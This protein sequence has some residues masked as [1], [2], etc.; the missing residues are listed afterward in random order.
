MTDYIENTN[1][2]RS[3]TLE[4]ENFYSDFD[5]TFSSIDD[6]FDKIDLACGN[7][8]DSLINIF[9]LLQKHHHETSKYVSDN[10]SDVG[11]NS[12]F[13]SIDVPGKK[14]D[15]KT[16]D[17]FLTEVQN[18]LRDL[19]NYDVD[20][21]GK[22]LCVDYISNALDR[23]LDYTKNNK[24]AIGDLEYHLAHVLCELVADCSLS[25][26]G[27]IP[28]SKWNIGTENFS[29]LSAEDQLLSSLNKAILIDRMYLSLH[30]LRDTVH[31]VNR[32]A[33]T[34]KFLNWKIY[35]YIGFLNYK[36][37]NYK[38]AIHFFRKIE[39]DGRVEAIDKD[40]WFHSNLLI[41]YCFEY[42]FNFI[43]AINKLACSVDELRSF[44]NNIEYKNITNDFESVLNR[45]FSKISELENNSLI[46]IYFDHN[47][48][49]TDSC[50]TPEQLE[51]LHALAHCINEYSAIEAVVNNTNSNLKNNVDE[52]TESEAVIS[53]T[54]LNFGDNG[55]LVFFARELMRFIAKREPEYLTCYA[56]I[57]GECS[58]YFKAL[59][60]LQNARKTLDRR[61]TRKESLDAEIDFFEYYFNQMLGH[62]VK[63]NKER[64][65]N[66]CWKYSD[67]DAK[68]HIRIFEFKNALK[69][70]YAK[71]SNLLGEIDDEQLSQEHLSHI[72][73]PPIDELSEM[74]VE[75]CKLSQSL[76][77]N[78][79]V[80]AE[81]RAVQRAYVCIKLFV[82]YLSQNRNNIS[83]EYVRLMNA[84]E[85]FYHVR[86]DYDLENI[87][88]SSESEKQVTIEN[89]MF[90]GINDKM[91]VVYCLHNCESIFLLA[92]ISG[93]VVFQ[94]QTGKLNE[95]FDENIF[96][97]N[98]VTPCKL[99]LSSVKQRLTM[100]SV[101]YGT[102]SIQKISWASLRDDAVI[103]CWREPGDGKLVV[104]N[105]TKTEN[106]MVVD[107]DEF[108]K[109]FADL[110]NPKI[111]S[112]DNRFKGKKCR[113]YAK[114]IGWTE[115]INETSEQLPVFIYF[116]KRER[117]EKEVYI[118]PQ[119]Y[120]DSKHVFHKSVCRVE[121]IVDQQ[122]ES[123][124]IGSSTIDK[125]PLS[126]DKDLKQK[127]RRIEKLINRLEDLKDNISNE[128]DYAYDD[129]S[130][131][132]EWIDNILKW[133]KVDDA[134][135]IIDTDL[136]E[137]DNF[138]LEINTL[139]MN[140]LMEKY[141]KI[142]REEDNNVK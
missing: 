77:M 23:V 94:Y 101:A 61:G 113:V 40:K 31:H 27:V 139:D 141:R 64:F 123:S 60:E 126:E 125:E 115:I 71:L 70:Y 108:Y 78:V 43:E 87:D 117:Y 76:Y 68:C 114:V 140:I 36:I 67:N 16:Y 14:A 34:F 41:A 95:L 128:N 91:S 102:P 103:Y 4:V 100:T 47:M 54:I 124:E 37:H 53:N 80:R 7:D 5:K 1:K 20:W 26:Q 11:T 72:K 58:D 18:N 62:E 142:F 39:N 129:H 111:C 52:S 13:S 21:E 29:L 2:F 110:V 8:S 89:A 51:I 73:I 66:Y 105:K 138:L 84:F 17:I 107:K 93:V 35:Y 44:L 19:L 55:K 48:K 92:P 69:E 85:R 118:V 57:H 131:K 88:A 9:E 25:I 59:T 65:D 136:D 10:C 116:H 127:K 56:T 22:T 24:K 98:D 109:L 83:A 134:N 135:N 50:F 28:L 32:A 12:V 96:M 130:M 3:I 82:E 81:L 137:V 75:M 132:K 79:N 119:K 74:Y 112:S 15:L 120:V 38:E 90:D 106:R 63:N 121:W 122:K 99:N 97:I 46:S 49:L 33:Y 133:V 30:S 86:A 104:V 42:Q 6:L 45:F